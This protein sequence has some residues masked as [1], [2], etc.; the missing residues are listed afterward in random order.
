MGA[1]NLEHNLET[2]ETIHTE[3]IEET[4]SDKLV[5]DAELSF[6][7]SDF[8]LKMTLFPSI[9]SNKKKFALFLSQKVS[10]IMNAVVVIDSISCLFYCHMAWRS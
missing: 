4:S 2:S 8:K 5:L 3:N 10:A 9:S 6:R 7:I 1:E